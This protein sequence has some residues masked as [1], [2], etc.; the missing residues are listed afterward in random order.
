MTVSSGNLTFHAEA[1]QR[2]AVF[3]AGDLV[4]LL[5]CDDQ[6]FYILDKVVKCG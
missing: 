4:L 5:T 1:T 2:G 3:K 6:M